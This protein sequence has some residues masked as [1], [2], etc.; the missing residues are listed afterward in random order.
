MAPSLLPE[1]MTTRGCL[2]SICPKEGWG[3]GR[4]V[5][6][7]VQ[8][9]HRRPEAIIFCYGLRRA[10][11]RGE[12]SG[13]DGILGANC[14]VFLL[15]TRYTMEFPEASLLHGCMRLWSRSS[16]ERQLQGSTCSN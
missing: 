15:G 1:K 12:S 3:L 13:T 16:C 9:T 5:R 11:S 2:R 7:A 6:W 10:G 8:T 4:A 14:G